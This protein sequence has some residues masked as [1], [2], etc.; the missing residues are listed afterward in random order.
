MLIFKFLFKHIIIVF[1]LINTLISSYVPL[2][3]Q[4]SSGFCDRWKPR[5]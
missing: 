3:Q 2:V 4:N 1:N 5:N